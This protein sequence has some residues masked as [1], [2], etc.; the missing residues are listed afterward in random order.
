MY[1]NRI[2]VYSNMPNR[3]LYVGLFCLFYCYIL[4][5]F[6]VFLYYLQIFPIVDIYRTYSS[7]KA[8]FTSISVFF[9]PI[10]ICWSAFSPSD[11]E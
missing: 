9:V 7:L 3:L 5:R 1:N 8:S 10:S 4:K 11:F 6:M 2:V